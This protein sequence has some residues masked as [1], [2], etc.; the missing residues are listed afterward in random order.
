MEPV[1][2]DQEMVR[3]NKALEDVFDRETRREELAVYEAN[4]KVAASIMFKGAG[5]SFPIQAN[6]GDMW[7]NTTDGSDYVW[8]GKEWMLISQP[9]E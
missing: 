3:V 9:L 5:S 7:M 4:L 1:T 2:F 6:V 8:S